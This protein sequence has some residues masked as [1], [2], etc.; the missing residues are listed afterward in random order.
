MTDE[1]EGSEDTEF[2]LLGLPLQDESHRLRSREPFELLASQFV[3]E[4]RTGKKPSI[5]LY[6]RRYPPHAKQ[7]REVF[8]VLA[9]LENARIEKESQSIRRHMPDRFPFNRLGNCELLKELGRGGMGVVFKGRDLDSGH[10]VAIKVL[11]WRTTIVPGWVERFEREARTAAQLRHRNIVPVFRYGQENGYCYF[12]MQLV[13]GVGLDKVIAAL[14]RPEG[15]VYV[16][17]L[18]PPDDDLPR[19]RPLGSDEESKAT[20]QIDMQKLQAPHVERRRVEA[21]PL[22]SDIVDQ[23]RQSRASG[24][25]GFER[26]SQSRNHAQ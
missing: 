20:N 18:Q 24:D 11:P 19:L 14:K 4:I 17:E 25:S 3:E 23:L 2:Q 13:R 16:E 12:V 10:L 7:I 26:G 1:P 6:A 21:P 8:P 9:M 5:E 15:V 22:D